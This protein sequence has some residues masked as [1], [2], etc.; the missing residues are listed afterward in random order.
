MK[1]FILLIVAGSFAFTFC[2]KSDNPISP[3]TN[4]E[5]ISTPYKTGTVT[6]NPN[7][8]PSNVLGTYTGTYSTGYT[9]TDSLGHFIFVVLDSHP[10]SVT[11]TQGSA[12]NIL[13]A[14]GVDFTYNGS[15][16]YSYSPSY[17]YFSLSF[18]GNKM[19]FNVSSGM[20]NSSNFVGV[21]Q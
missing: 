6:A 20:A 12:S 11:L 4:T 19:Y 18:I 1:K 15:S 13:I 16:Y 5:S 9:S 2:K 3:S 7:P 17:P 10:Q 14:F 8:I 21:K